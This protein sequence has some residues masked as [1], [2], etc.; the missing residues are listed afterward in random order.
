MLNSLEIRNVVLIESLSLALSPGLT[1]VTGETGAGKSILLDALGLALG[2]RADARLVR[3]GAERASVTAG[4]LL[5]DARLAGLADVLE[6]LDLGL[7]EGEPLLL[8]RVVRRDGTSRAYVND[9][10]VSVSLLRRIGERLVEVHGQHDER[11]LLN[12]A[13]HRA[14]LDAF[15]GV[16][17]ER[18]AVAR[19]F[20]RIAGIEE[21]IAGLER[22]A[23]TRA[24][25]REWLDHAITELRELAPRPGEEAELAG[26]RARL[27]RVE[28]IAGDL[29]EIWRQVMAEGGIDDLARQVLRRLER[30]TS[31]EID[32]VLSPAIAAFDRAAI[33]MAEGVAALT[34]A[35]D[36]LAFDP[37]RL[38]SVEERLFALRGVARKHQVP[39][40]ELP[41]LLERLEAR[42]AALETG[43]ER[44]ETLRVARERAEEELQAAVTALRKARERA[45]RCLDRMVMAELEP[46]RLG[47][48]RF[49]TRITPLDRS[50]WSA[51]GGERVAFEVATSPGA[52]FGPLS[53]IASGGEL[54]RF[55][56]ALKVVLADRGGAPTLIFDEVDRGI[57]GATA[58]AVGG[59]LA[60]LAREAQVLLVTHSPQV[61]AHADHH[62]SIEKCEAAGST[63]DG[64]LPVTRLRTLDGEE[65]V[66][67]IARMLAGERV[68]M[69]A[70]E[71]ARRLL[72]VSRGT[73]AGTVEDGETVR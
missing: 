11:G 8:R 35:R 18:A 16:E 68:T 56:L 48:A 23:A 42:R 67:E 66:A 61:A 45:A 57:G 20:A 31:E 41:A 34:R 53:R 47:A 60:R 12:P 54:A 21:E 73:V 5:E 14:L 72:A 38:E 36:S 13:G 28:R 9:Q 55:I 62:L 33:E 29:E 46:L 51:E 58:A 4:F 2:R 63:A 44:L 27:M 64:R 3:A 7:C 39:V 71:A 24:E 22:A 49:R 70:C 17:K 15:A 32:D 25:D 37:A 26:E 43:D 69:E 40:E 52:D 59:R 6:D 1:A 30:I 19:A 10:P 65:R 50:G